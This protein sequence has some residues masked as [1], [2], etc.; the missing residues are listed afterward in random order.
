MPLSG[1]IVGSGFG[2]AAAGVVESGAG[3]LYGFGVAPA[4]AGWTVW[5]AWATRVARE[6]RIERPIARAWKSEMRCAGRKTCG[7]CM[8]RT[9]VQS[10][11]RSRDRAE[12]GRHDDRLR[13]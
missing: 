4:K 3:D 6:V 9:G 13:V 12:F 2:F 10:D 1:A 7:N 5:D 8:T 11:D